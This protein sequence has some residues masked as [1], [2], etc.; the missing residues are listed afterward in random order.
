MVWWFC[1]VWFLVD[2]GWWWLFLFGSLGSVVLLLPGERRFFSWVFSW[3]RVLFS[4]VSLCSSAMIFLFSA[5]IR[6]ISFCSPRIIWLLV[7]LMV[8]MAACK[9]SWRLEV[10]VSL[11]S[12]LVE[13]LD[14]SGFMG[15]SF[16]GVGL[17]VGASDGLEE[18]GSR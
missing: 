12:S 1:L 16:V 14:D 6:A 18:G 5:L 7:S 4:A 15:V 2:D 13:A 9:T 10:W 17:G 3:L 11:G 8:R